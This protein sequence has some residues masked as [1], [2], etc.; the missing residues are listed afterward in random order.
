MLLWLHT[1]CKVHVCYIG[2]FTL[3]C[4]LWFV[5]G[6]LSHECLRPRSVSNIICEVYQKLR[7]QYTRVGQ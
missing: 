2:T 6:H 7:Q 1:R 3:D 5:G 4:H